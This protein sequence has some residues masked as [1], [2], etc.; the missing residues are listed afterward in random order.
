MQLCHS[1][2]LSRGSGKWSYAFLFFTLLLLTWTSEGAP[3][4]ESIRDSFDLHE[5]EG[6]A[7]RFRERPTSRS[8]AGPSGKDDDIFGGDD[9]FGKD[10]PFAKDDIF[11]KDDFLDKGHSNSSKDRDRKEDHERG[12]S[13][14][15][16]ADR[17]RS[18]ISDRS[19]EQDRFSDDMRANTSRHSSDPDPFGAGLDSFSPSS[20]N[21][22]PPAESE[23]FG[24]HSPSQKPPAK[25]LWT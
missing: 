16:F 23:K 4:R 14:S 7:S 12:K 10:D 6:S 2:S 21:D 19:R 22:Q 18:S 13:S 15:S 24:V 11:G 20:F 1:S 3:I 9:L 17:D 5:K 25:F 8:K